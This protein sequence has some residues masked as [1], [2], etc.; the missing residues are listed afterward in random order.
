MLTFVLAIWTCWQLF[1]G[2]A[3][4]RATFGLIAPLTA[5]GVVTSFATARG[6]GLM[7][8]AYA[9]TLLASIGQLE[10]TLTPMFPLVRAAHPVGVLLFACWLVAFARHWSLEPRVVAQER[11]E[12]GTQVRGFATAG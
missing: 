5:W 4:E 6:S 2:P 1:A 3:S 10:R 9:I 7:A 12:P 11:S 8:I